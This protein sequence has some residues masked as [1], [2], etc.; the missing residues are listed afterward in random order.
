M[1]LYEHSLSSTPV[2]FPLLLFESYPSIASLQLSSYA[3]TQTQLRPQRYQPTRMSDDDLFEYEEIWIED[4]EPT[5][6]DDLAES[7]LHDPVIFGDPGYDSDNYF[8]DLEYMSDEYFDDE[9]VI[10]QRLSRD[11]KRK[12]DGS[13]KRGE[14]KGKTAKGKEK[15]KGNGNGLDERSFRGVVWKDENTITT[16]ETGDEA[17][18]KKGLY[19]PGEGEKVAL[20]KNWREIFR[21]SRPGAGHNE[22]SGTRRKKETALTAVTSPASNAGSRREDSSDQASGITSLDTLRENEMVDSNT[23]TSPPMSTSPISVKEGLESE[24][25]QN[26]RDKPSKRGN[27]RK[28]AAVEKDEKDTSKTESK[29]PKAKKTERT[30]QP[31]RRSTRRTAS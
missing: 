16:P 8:T 25:S 28:A 4:P 5:L 12:A 14:P 26:D 9:P 24:A 17:R 18:K 13:G 21:T 15:G 11:E 19:P 23:N 29:R 30:A 22:S 6:A 31:P 1:S 10:M 27:K 7:A 20:L 2:F 3:T